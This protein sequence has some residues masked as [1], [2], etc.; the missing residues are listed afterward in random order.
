M[1]QEAASPQNEIQRQGAPIIF[2]V[3]DDPS[4]LRALSAP[5]PS[6]RLPSRAEFRDAPAALGRKAP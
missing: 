2:L 3:D 1:I 4:F 5:P 6:G